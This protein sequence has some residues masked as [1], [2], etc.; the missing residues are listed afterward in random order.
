MSDQ[1]ELP[2]EA[3]PACGTESL[4]PIDSLGEEVERRVFEGKERWACACGYSEDR[5]ASEEFGP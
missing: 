2:T 5:D 3:C 4:R 1:P